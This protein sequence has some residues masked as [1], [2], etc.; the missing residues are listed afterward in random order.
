[1]AKLFH[2]VD[3]VSEKNKKHKEHSSTIR[4]LIG[5]E[6]MRVIGRAFD[7]GVVRD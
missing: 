6:G 1:M 4:E 3:T 5:A 2:T 7:K